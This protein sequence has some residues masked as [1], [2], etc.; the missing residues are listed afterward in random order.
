MDKNSF[1]SRLKWMREER[2]YTQQQLAEFTGISLGSIRRYE[3]SKNGSI[4]NAEYL[5]KLA[6]ILD[7]TP[8]FL[9]KGENDMN[10]Y[11]KAIWKE[12]KQIKNFE[13]IKRIK[14]LPL[15]GTILSHLELSDGLIDAIRDEWMR[16]GFFDKYCTHNYIREVVLRYCQNRYQLRKEFELE[17]GN[18]L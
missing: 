14:D 3:Q 11:T 15:N 9:L 18:L 16:K 12:L 13:Q 17:D 5:L 2:G 6:E 8:E 10:N 7:I 1:A 4:S